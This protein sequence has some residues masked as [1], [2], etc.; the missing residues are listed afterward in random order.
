MLSK[1]QKI[2]QKSIT[3]G[4]LPNIDLL[5]DLSNSVK[6]QALTPSSTGLFCSA[7][8]DTIN[9]PVVAVASDEEIVQE[10]YDAL[11][12]FI[13][14]ER[15]FHFSQWE[16]LPFDTGEPPL[17]VRAKHLDALYALHDYSRDKTKSPP[18]IAVPVRALAHKIFSAD[19]FAELIQPVRKN[20]TIDIDRFIEILLEA[21]YEQT[22]MVESRG[23]FAVRGGII[24]IYP[25]NLERALRLDLFGDEVESIR[26]FDV[27]SQ[28]SLR[29]KDDLTQVT[30]LP[31]KET[32]LL[33]CALE[34]EKIRSFL[35]WLPHESTLFLFDPEHVEESVEDYWIKIEQGFAQ[36]CAKKESTK[37]K[38]PDKLFCRQAELNESLNQ[39]RRILHQPIAIEAKKEDDRVIDF[40]TRIFEG[41]S[42]N[43]ESYIAFLK[44]KLSTGYLI[45]ISCDNVGQAW[46]LEEILHQHDLPAAAE[47]PHPDK[48][49]DTHYVEFRKKSPETYISL[50]IGDLHDGFILPSLKLV[51]LTDR[52]IFGRYKKRH[53][54]RRFYKGIPVVG[55]DEIRRGD[56]VVHV[57]HGIGQFR[58]I[59]QQVIDEKRIDLLE[60]EY[61]DN[62]KLL[63]PVDK[64]QYIQKYSGVEGLEPALDKLGSKRWLTRKKKTREAIEKMAKELLEIYAHRSIAKGQSFSEDTVWQT[65]FEATF[66]FDET[67]DQIQAIEEVKKDLK[68]PKPM[69]RLL[70]GD[71]GYGKTE[72]AIRAA[73][74]VVRE[75]K[76]VALLCPTTILAQQHYRTFSERFASFDVTVDMLS[77]FRTRQQQKA[78]LHR[79]KYGEISVII[80]THR[81]LSDDVEF[82]DLGLVIVDE[83]QRFGVRHKEKLKKL[84]A[85]VD[86]LTLTATPIPRT[87]Y[88]ALSGLRDLSIINTPPAGRLP[89]KTKII[90]FEPELIKEAILRE[91]NRGGQIYFVH[92]RIDNIHK[93]AQK[94]QDILPDV[95]LA[96]AHGRMRER[97]LEKVMLDFIEKR[98]DV[99]LSTTIIE[100]GLDIS[101]VNTIIINRADAF[102]LAQLYQLRGRIGRDI[103]QAYAYMVLPKGVPVTETAVRRL[104]AIEEFTELGSGFNLAMRDLEIR[105]AGNL[106]GKEQHGCIVSIG[107]DLYCKLLEETVR[108]L[109]G[110]IVEDTDRPV[111]IKLEVDAFLPTH[112]VGVESLRIGIYKRLAQA[113]DLR[114][115]SDIKDEIRDRY[116]R[117]PAPVI[118]LLMISRL[119][120]LSRTLGIKSIYQSGD[121]FVLVTTDT[122][123]DLFRIIQ[124]SDV[125]VKVRVRKEDDT[126]LSVTVVG[127]NKKPRRV[128]KVLYSLL[129]S[130]LKTAEPISTSEV[131]KTKNSLPVA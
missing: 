80:G 1:L 21:G 114:E 104:A 28:R 84:R 90:H 88:M 22:S 61:L 110:E 73:H 89:I 87:L 55:A 47:P 53:I 11:R 116:G 130:T 72:V 66:P 91:I 40:K 95:R 56:Y 31:A 96:V 35:E 117:I 86:F 44:E 60:I 108:R 46:R 69:D 111:E 6:V 103:R 93:I 37:I 122:A 92:N 62:D 25:P 124:E 75:G 36:A 126:R 115:I 8:A 128:I 26:Y 29:T 10:I 14:E 34:K 131:N 107:F 39:F 99:L 70:C 83:E 59:R 58:G 121:R 109:R 30:I 112:Y 13:G 123:D 50:T 101:N 33:L 85:S 97:E 98:F 18:V 20:H 118:N 63:V 65:E 102:G 9:A 45:N 68:E 77:R 19:F 38:K 16:T 49:S 120:I 42:S 79:L 64:I 15:A 127:K 52:E 78:I 105:G 4:A 27:Y 100:N 106:L 7:L 2:W 3:Q 113:R 94:L 54:F 12:Y 125:K 74:K 51:F 82:S 76:Q 119:R 129:S 24:D 5:R 41:M 43:V 17:E 81:L 67:P 48:K 57:D 23:E 32:A 71:V